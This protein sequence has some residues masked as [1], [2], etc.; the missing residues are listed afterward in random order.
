MSGLP[1][2]R[3]LLITGPPAVGK[4]SL[5][6]FLAD[7]VAP[8]AVVEADDVW[9]LV[10]SGAVAPWQPGEGAR[11]GEMAAL[12]AALLMTSFHTHGFNVI[13]TDILLGNS[14][15]A[16]AGSSVPPLVVHLRVPVDEALRRAGSARGDLTAEEFRLLHEAERG[17]T[18]ADV[19]LETTRLSVEKCAA[20][21]LAL[22][23][24]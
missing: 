5:A 10:K 21:I 13:A 17:A 16:Y 2:L 19:S 24:D 22:W 7:A 8:C 20:R 6:S 23:T 14:F 15:S 11:Q 1:V 4:S 3:P 18:V 9:R 12:H